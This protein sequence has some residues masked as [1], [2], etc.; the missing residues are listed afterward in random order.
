MTCIVGIKEFDADG[1]VKRLLMA[2]DSFGGDGSTGAKFLKPKVFKRGDFVMGVCG[3]YRVMQLL[4]FTLKIP[5]K[6][7]SQS[8]E[9]YLYSDFVEAVRSCLINGGCTKVSENGIQ[10]FPAADFVFGY[11]KQLYFMQ[12]DFSILEPESNYYSTGSGSKHASASLYTTEKLNMPVEDRIQE[13]FDCTSHFV[14]SVNNSVT[15]VVQE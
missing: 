11:N 9:S 15:I 4:E 1:N 8:T 12:D 6:S 3:S 10:S 2:G 14:T 7:N 5:E 13:A